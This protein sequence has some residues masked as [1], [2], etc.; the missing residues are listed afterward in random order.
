MALAPAR[1]ARADGPAL[2]YD[3]GPELHRDGRFDGPLWSWPLPLVIA[4]FTDVDGP[5]PGRWRADKLPLDICSFQPPRTA[6]FSAEQFRQATRDAA[7]T[8]NAAEAGAG[9]RYNG[10]CST[11][12]RY[13]FGNRRNEIGFDDERNAVRG[14][15]VAIARGSWQEFPAFGPTERRDFTE[16]DVIVDGQQVTGIPYQCLQSV[17]THEIG[18]VLGFGHSTTRGDLM[19]ESFSPSDLSTCHTAPSA[20]ERAKLQELYGRDRAPTVS[21]GADRA[22]TAGATVTLAA[23]ATDPEGQAV[24]YTW[25]QTAGP[26]VSLS[27]SGASVSFIAP[28]TAEPLQFEVTATDPLLH[29][30]TASTRVTVGAATRPPAIAPSFASFL[31]GA[32]GAAELGWEGSDGATA[33]QFCSYPPGSPTAQRCFDGSRP[34]VP[35]DLQF[36]PDTQGLATATRVFVNDVHQTSLSACNPKGCSPAGIGP[37]ASGIRWPA[38]EIGFDYFALGFDFGRLQFT[39]VG[40]VN[41]SGPSRVFTLNTGPAADPNLARIRSCDQLSKG[42]VCVDFLGPGKQQYDTVTIVSTRDGTPTTEHR[43]TVR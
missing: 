11:G 42:D 21:A 7:R 23:S 27:S 9:V 33:Y 22:V 1:A 36:T 13:E 39:I 10:D 38:W 29:S 30:A 31:P 6:S 35:I 16:F 3:D 20:A 17:I 25:R 4:F 2:V 14:S 26:A 43:I 41:V 8:W 15:R 32:S 24:S 37:L 12:T 34:L 28:A 19:F 5:P 18:H 40:V